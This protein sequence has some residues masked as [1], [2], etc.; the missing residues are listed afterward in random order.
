M[1]V[2]LVTFDPTNEK[3]NTTQRNKMADD[4][5]RIPEGDVIQLT[6]FSQVKHLSLLF[7][8]K[9][10]CT[11]L[12]ICSRGWDDGYTDFGAIDKCCQTSILVLMLD[13]WITFMW[14][15]IIKRKVDAILVGKHSYGD[16]T[17]TVD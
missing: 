6:S 13:S 5:T 14:L 16:N 2:P 10:V 9:S 4:K 15:E 11:T 8:V 3:E 12:L 7:L 17:V 1:T